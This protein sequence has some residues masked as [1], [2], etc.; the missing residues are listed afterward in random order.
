LDSVITQ[1]R[2]AGR[3]DFGAAL[4]AGHLLKRSSR[5]EEAAAAYEDASRL[6]PQSPLPWRSRADLELARDQRSEAAEA[7][8]RAIENISDHDSQKIDWLIELGDLYQGQSEFEKAKRVWT[9][10]AQLAP[11]NLDLRL[12]LARISEKNHQLD[13]AIGHY[14]VVATHGSPY[15]KTAAFREIARLERGRH[16]FAE[17]VSALE[18]AIEMTAPGNWVR[19]DLQTQLIQIYQEAD[20]GVE[21][22]EK[23]Q[24]QA[25]ANPRDLGALKQLAL[26]YERCGR[27]EEECATLRQMVE[28]MPNTPGFKSRLADLTALEGNLAEAA[29]LYDEL[30]SQQPTNVDFQLARARLDVQLGRL[31]EAEGRV[32]ALVKNKPQDDG[33]RSRVIDFLNRYRLETAAGEILQQAAEANPEEDQPGFVQ[34]LLRRH[35]FLPA[36]IALEGWLRSD[37]GRYTKA[38]AFFKEAGYPLEAEALLRLALGFDAQNRPALEALLELLIARNDLAEARKWIEAS[39]ARATD[40][41]W[42]KDLDQRLFILLSATDGP[43]V[44]HSL[45]SLASVKNFEIDTFIKALAG[46][47][48]QTNQSADYLRLAVWRDWSNDGEGAVEAAQRAVD[49]DSKNTAARERLVGFAI[50]TKNWNVAQAQLRELAE[51]NPSAP[52]NYLGKLADLY[53]QLGQ[54]QNA[55]ICL[56]KLKSTVGSNVP[57]LADLAV[58]FQRANLPEEELE[59]W[60]RAYRQAIGPQRK[61]ILDQLVRSL[62]EKGQT[63]KAARA[64]L[65]FFDEQTNPNEQR[66]AFDALLDHCD[67]TALLP[68]LEGEI[69]ERRDQHPNDYFLQNCLVNVLQREGRTVEAFELLQKAYFCAPDPATALRSLVAEAERIGKLA[70]ARECQRKLTY[71]VPPDDPQPLLK[72]AALETADFHDASG[73]WNQLIVRFPRDVEVLTQAAGYFDRKLF[74]DR[75]L[76]LLL[77]VIDL[78]PDN[79]EALYRVG[80]IRQE[81]QEFGTA[82]SCFERVIAATTIEEREGEIL[83]YPLPEF[84]IGSTGYEAA[85]RQRDWYTR[86]GIEDSVRGF[87]QANHQT[88]PATTDLDRR[89]DSVVRWVTCLKTDSAWGEVVRSVWCLREIREPTAA[90]W[91]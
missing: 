70:S 64:L 88:R 40:A 54:V 48:L 60:D 82:R 65:D 74:P 3:K 35:R 91:A 21:L 61:E 86:G 25:R 66:M 81:R 29:R 32:R 69:G 11:G 58:A 57:K 43:A 10:A 76:E 26:F 44:I 17:A 15:Q 18:R 27:V 56:Q 55:T 8:E 9:A 28:L 78:D 12:Q 77:R 50:K 6:N 59:T 46:T 23:W 83:R 87:W 5:F 63:T 72:L 22:E 47:A 51:E 34:F 30:V 31:V 7:L 75:V 4:I 14:Q 42:R 36:R 73:T 45:P 85:L 16:H 41:E 49:R 2:A 13:D 53:L 68:W 62:T 71:F 84:T 67:R 90:L 38:A 33:L 52:A 1:Y 24:S 19:S 89:L 79:V 20:R 39:Y 37:R 80:C